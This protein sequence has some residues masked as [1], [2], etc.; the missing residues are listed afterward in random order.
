MNKIYKT[1]WNRVTK[2]ISVVSEL[3]K[4]HGDGGSIV[5]EPK[6]KVVLGLATIGMVFPGSYA[7]ASSFLWDYFV[8]NGNEKGVLTISSDGYRTEGSSSWVKGSLLGNDDILIGSESAGISGNV[9]VNGTDAT[10]AAVYGGYRY[11]NYMS[12]DHVKGNAVAFKDGT[13]GIGDIN[14]IFNEIAFHD[15]GT[16]SVDYSLFE[17]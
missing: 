9:T 5:S 14:N 17:Y 12:D 13:V 7:M 6:K 16:T 8:H 4:S 3:A 10:I 11:G 1:I 2:C 15:D